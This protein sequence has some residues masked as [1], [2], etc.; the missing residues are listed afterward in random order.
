MTAQRVGVPDGL[1]I[2]AVVRLLQP[3]FPDLTVSK[4]RYLEAAG[5]VRPQ[6]RESG[7]RRF[8][9]DDLTRL[10]FVLT[11]Q[12]DRFWPLKVIREALDRMDQGLEPE[13]RAGLE[14]TDVSPGPAEAPAEQ[15][16]PTLPTPEQLR[17]RRSVR[18]TPAELRA[19]TAL[20]ATAYAALKG[21]GMIRTDAAGRHGADDVD[22]A[23]HCAALASFGLEPRHLRLFRVAADR[24]IGLTDQ[25]LEPLRRRQARGATDIDPERIQAQ[26]LAHS[27][28]LHV[29]LVR[30]GLER[31]R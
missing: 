29:A 22:V 11:S 27:L 24:E 5:L 17:R 31:G 10:R 7:L 30:A 14:S 23:R 26:I 9:D 28:A 21:F 2:G 6:R 20:D 8:T 4:V 13:R 12:R 3:E 19:Q 18:L 25:I 1:S 15:V 16:P